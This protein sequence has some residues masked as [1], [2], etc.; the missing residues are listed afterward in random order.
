MVKLI[1]KFNILAVFCILLPRVLSAQENL[2]DYNYDSIAAD[3]PIDEAAVISR[4]SIKFH[5]DALKNNLKFKL[6]DGK[7]VKVRL[8]NNKK[9]RTKLQ[10][11]TVTYRGYVKE[12]SKKRGSFQLSM[13]EDADG[14]SQINGMLRTKEGDV[15]LMKQKDSTSQELLKL[16]ESRQIECTDAPNMHPEI[17]SNMSVNNDVRIKTDTT[18]GLLIAYTPDAVTEAGGE[19]ALQTI[20]NTMVSNANLA[21]ANSHTGVTY[22]LLGIQALS[23]YPTDDFGDDLA[24]ATDLHDGKW[25][26]LGNLREEYCADQV[27]VIVGG[28]NGQ[29]ICGIAWLGGNADVMSS[30]K[31]SMFSIISA[32]QSICSYLTFAHELGH[33]LGSAHDFDNSG[34]S[35]AYNYSFGYRFNG[36]SNQQ[37]RTVMAYA[38]GTR[39]PYFSNPNISYDGVATGSSTANNA[40]SI[41]LTSPVVGAFYG[42]G[43]TC[44]NHN[45]MPVSPGVPTAQPTTLPATQVDTI[46]LSGRNKSKQTNFKVQALGA[47]I[48]VSGVPVIIYYDKTGYGGFTQSVASG[49][50]NANGIKKFTKRRKRG[51]YAACTDSIC[52]SANYY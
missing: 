37:F 22:S 20:I 42:E 41:A 32:N 12:H 2:F 50:T 44:G 39:I 15:Y 7:T 26:E 14:N 36:N 4:H 17:Q 11:E 31:D 1:I 38:P 47:G 8:E 46:L 9:T 23:T 29:T 33:N 25:D 51:Y 27:S 43:T 52:S 13:T 24:A 10:F 34:G 30:Y 49:N 35:G 19:A 5:K 18:I 40:G 21:H 16:D 45:P 28:T 6:P 48:G 3:A